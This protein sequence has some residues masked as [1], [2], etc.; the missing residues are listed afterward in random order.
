MVSRAR[1]EPSSKKNV[2]TGVAI[3][4]TELCAADIRLRGSSDRAFRVPLDPPNGDGTGWAS[5]TSALADLARNI[6]V[7]EGTLAVSLMPPLT[8]MRRL[9]L[10]PLRDDELQRLLSRNASK[11]FV[12]ARTPQLVGA[13]PAGRRVRGAPSPVIAAAAS[14]RLLAAIRA[15]AQ[16]AGW[17]VEG[18]AP[19]E[20]AW[21]GAA[22]A[23][24]P[25]FARQTAYALI[26]HDDR[27]DLLQLENGG[28]VN[29][30]RFR[31][32]AADAPMII[33]TV[34]PVARIGVA[35][36]VQQR[37]ELSGALASLGV[38]P[39]SPVGEWSAAAERA[40][41][42]AAQFAGSE[43]GPV[44]RTDDAVMLARDRARK[45]TWMIAGATAALF[46]IAAMIELWGVHHQLDLI[47]A[48]RAR[49]RPQIASTLIGRTT[50]DAAYGHLATL[51][52]VER[53]SP[54]W[55]AVVA[56]LTESVPDDAHLIAIRAR[57]DSLI[58]D[59]LASHAARVFD[60]VE[61][62]NG[63]ADVRAASPVR[64]ELQDEGGAL[65]HFTIAARVVRPA[66]NP[67]MSAAAKVVP[68][69]ERAP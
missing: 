49:I 64:R 63:L 61:K 34:G 23:I 20:S 28:L 56:D 62:T 38:T 1:V 50:V 24:W 30:R 52:A 21:A 46:V 10:P 26:A 69:R 3:S 31:A 51:N 14:I 32:G 59:G 29:V 25:A 68:S 36:S 44:L 16:Q 33:D 18:I 17:E 65:E 19:A 2:R 5:L 66:V 13:A 4:P 45:H 58:V 67:P 12:S 8:E 9:E 15:S 55:S 42:L 57:E 37:K 35:G 60:A 11:Y 7:T 43:V 41:L 39:L 54:H 22:L 47:R 48:E 27:T 40:D 53:A 6:G